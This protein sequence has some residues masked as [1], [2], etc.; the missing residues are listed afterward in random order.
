MKT[1]PLIRLVFLLVVFITQFIVLI[2]N[3][4]TFFTLQNQ[5]EQK[6]A[7]LQEEEKEQE[8]RLNQAQQ[9]IRQEMESSKNNETLE[10]ID[11]TT[12]PEDILAPERPDADKDIE[13]NLIDR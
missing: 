2:L 4:N 1:N 7:I 3:I 11:D 8:N 12:K 10:R 13:Q 5:A 6:E 9:N